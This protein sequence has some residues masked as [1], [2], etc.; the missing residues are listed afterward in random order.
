MRNKIYKWA[1]AVISLGLTGAATYL[2]AKICDKFDLSGTG[3]LTSRF[4]K[5]VMQYRRRTSDLY[6]F[7]QIFI[8]R[9]Y[10][11]LDDLEHIRSII[12]CGAYV[13]FS[14]AYFLTRFPSSHV[15]AIEPDPKNFSVLRKVAPSGI[16]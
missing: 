15:V 2:I 3:L 7:Q 14:S 1:K 5:H 8:E 11:C 16:A 9:E 6:T 10:A 4:A 13:G 12:D